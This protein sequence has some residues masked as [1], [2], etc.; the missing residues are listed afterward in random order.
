MATLW[1]LTDEFQK[2]Y[3]DEEVGDEQLQLV[4]GQIMN[5]AEGA[6]KFIQSL[7]ADE[8]SIAEEIAYLALKKKRV[9]SKIERM[10]N[11]V[12]E[13]MIHINTLKIQA[14]VF[15][16]AV[17]NNSASSVVITGPAEDLPSEWQKI[18]VE[19]DKKQIIADIK[20]GNDLVDD[21]SKVKVVTGKHLRI[22]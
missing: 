11:Y 4:A 21:E 16:L 10:K 9:Q 20:A 13:N 1:D 8:K 7:Q 3:D 15:T 12:K 19:P 2:L 17:Q 22:R 14:G 18:T 6:A 5:K